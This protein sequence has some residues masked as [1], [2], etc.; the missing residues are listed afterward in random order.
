MTLTSSPRPT[1]RFD[2]VSLGEVMLR[3][4]PGDTRIHT[5]RTFRVWE[6]G[7]EYNVARGLKRCF[8]LRTAVVTAFVD[9]PVGRLLEDL[10]YQGGVDQSHVRWV[11]DDGV[12]RTVRNGLNFTERGFGVRA[13]VGCS[14]RGHTAASQMKPGDVDW[15]RI[16]GQEGARWFHTG[17][18]LRRPL[19]DDAP[20]GEGGHGGGQEAR[21]D[22]LLRP[23]LPRVAV[24]VDRR[25]RSA[26]RR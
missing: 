15:D 24:E 8:G 22:R 23:Q 13:A 14:D 20:R 9:N 12:G 10:I 4:D 18:H 16:F 6:G 2:L 21:H 3:L 26:R 19:R 11:A 25:A 7:G 5:A 1:C 17:G